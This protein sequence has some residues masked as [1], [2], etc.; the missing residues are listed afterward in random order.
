M[1]KKKRIII[2]TVAG[3]VTASLL[4]GGIV[5]YASAAARVESCGVERS[6]FENVVELNGSIKS[7]TTKTF[8]GGAN[9]KVEEVLVKEGDRVKKGDLLLTFSREEI[10]YAIAM[11]ELEEQMDNGSYKNSTETDGRYRALYNEAV[12]NLNLLNEQ[13]VQTEGS[14][15]ELQ[16]QYADR[17]AALASD[18]AKIQISAMDASDPQSKE[19]TEKKKQAVNNEYLQ[20]HDEELRRIQ[21]QLNALNLQLADLK[22]SKAVMTSQKANSELALMSTGTKEELQ[23]RAECNR[24]DREKRMS[25]LVEAKDGIRAEYDGVVT[26]LGVVAGQSICTDMPLFTL[27]STTDVVV[28]CLANKYDIMS[29]K[30][31]QS[32]EVNA[33]GKTY[34]GM[35]V[36]IEG[37]V[38][39]DSGAGIGVDLSIDN[40]DDNIILGYDVKAHVNTV[41]L[42]NVISIPKEAVFS[43]EKEEYVY[44]EKDGKAVKVNVETG[45]KNDSYVEIVSGLSEGDV[46]IWDEKAELKDGAGVH[47]E[48]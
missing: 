32:M 40:P 18:G 5:R 38:G 28:H 1:K 48:R 19:Y 21:T 42:E 20:Q 36:R 45:E 24:M 13:I 34:T 35:I 10:D 29:L 11:I 16:K 26:G 22:E 8:F 14:I 41:A 27:E 30:L 33:F 46:V 9:L 7:N 23:A 15:V 17:M 31:G 37:T 12:A 2:G 47:V 4:L 39:S 25:R 3:V 44:I 6:S 43:D